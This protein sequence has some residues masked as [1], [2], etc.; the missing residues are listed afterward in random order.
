PPELA[1]ARFL[2]P[3]AVARLDGLVERSGAE[4]VLSSSWRI[5]TNVEHMQRL[6]DAVGCRA[7]LRDRTPRPD[8]HDPAVYRRWHGHDAPADGR[9][10]RGY[11]LQQWLDG[12]PD[13]EGI[14]ILDDGTRMG[15]LLPWLVRTSALRGLCDEHVELA[16]TCLARPGPGRG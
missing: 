6:L 8:E 9:L 16:L 3:A 12:Q 10:A 13:V 5:H 7:R 15:H 14:V 1:M 11:E 4:L 2:D